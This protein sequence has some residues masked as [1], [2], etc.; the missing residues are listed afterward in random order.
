M[1]TELFDPTFRTLQH[2]PPSP[3]TTG[4]VVSVVD[5]GN[6][7]YGVQFLGQTV[8]ARSAGKRDLTIGDIVSFIE[9]QPYPWAIKSDAFYPSRYKK[10]LADFA[11]S[12]PASVFLSYLLKDNPK[13]F[14]W[15]QGT[16]LAVI[17][18]STV[19]VLCWDGVVRSLAVEYPGEIASANEFSVGDPCLVYRPYEGT[20]VV[21][22][23]SSDEI[24]ELSG[25]ILSG[26]FQSPNGM[27][28]G[29]CTMFGG[30]AD[31][32]FRLFESDLTVNK[33][34]VDP[35]TIT[36]PVKFLSDG[37]NLISGKLLDG[38]PPGLFSGSLVWSDDN[39]ASWTSPADPGFQGNT[40]DFGIISG[41][42]FY[43]ERA[44]TAI[45]TSRYRKILVPT[46]TV[47]WSTDVI[48]NMFQATQGGA[49]AHQSYSADVLINPFSVTNP[50]L[51]ISGK[52]VDPD[53]QRYAH[54]QSKD[55][56]NDY[57]IDGFRIWQ[58]GTGLVLD[59]FNNT[60]SFLFP[61]LLNDGT[62]RIIRHAEYIANGQLYKFNGATWDLVT[63]PA[64]YDL[65]TYFY[66]C[67]IDSSGAT[68]YSCDKAD[69]SDPKLIRFPASMN[70]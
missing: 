65:H 3:K 64:P 12:K 46:E 58:A 41:Q 51:H 49:K 38:C 25:V 11:N 24:L 7:F 48:I 19:S 61:M 17:D 34:I 66:S 2:E 26:I 20:L 10:N 32:N 69:F 28:G 62:M 44:N 53:Y 8:T 50:F 30:V 23:K 42:M 14:T 40:C 56:L 52:S 70:I 21:V 16:I 67:G 1:K 18:S 39:G 5:A 37:N 22:G 60:G 68:Y 59:D 29:P 36:S 9:Q 13:Y 6:Y 35:G 43:I 31:T 55:G 33:S 15:R 4:R 63:L 54:C 57:W 27:V 47:D 45:A